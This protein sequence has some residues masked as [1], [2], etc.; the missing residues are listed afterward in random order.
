MALKNCKNVDVNRYELEISVDGAAFE[1]AINEVFKKQ[2]RKINIHGFRPGKAPRHIIEKLYGADVFY[3]EA[4]EK[5]YPEALDEAIKEAELKIIND[6]IGLEVVE[7]G[8]DGFTFKATVT[9]YPE[10]SIGEYKGLKFA[11]KSTEVTDELIDEEINKVRDRNSRLITVEDRVAQA[12]DIT[13]IDFEGFKD[14]V[15]F[16][17]G[18]A[19]NFNLTLGSGQFIPGFEEQLVG[20][21]TGE[22]FSINVKFPEEYQAEELAGADAEFKIKLHEIKCKELPELDDEFVKDVSEKDTVD[23]YKAELKEKIAE[24]LAKEADRAK[25]SQL[26]EQLVDLINA[27]I[28][29]AMFNNRVDAMINETSARIQSQGLDFNTYLQYTGMTVDQL[30]EQYMDQAKADVKL[31]LAVAKIAELENTEATDE[32]VEAEYTKLSEAY[33]VEIDK[34]KLYFPRTDL[35]ENIK[36]D[37]AMN[38]VL[39]SAVEK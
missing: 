19:E 12:G 1:K 39:D 11:P 36:L 17:G 15:A 25:E 22:E 3:D 5:L 30:K 24:R 6:K 4:M 9:T 18:K 32:D 27:D 13:V 31:N 29:E 16:E 34:V 20:H 7:A 26:C 35:E 2:A 21:K 8:K 37:K 10:V 23:E 33:G 14:G 28:P 38:I